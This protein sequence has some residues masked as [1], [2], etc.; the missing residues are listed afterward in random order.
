MLQLLSDT[1]P[2]F[3]GVS[4]PYENLD[5]L[6]KQISQKTQG[7]S[8]YVN[9]PERK[10]PDTDL[11]YADLDFTLQQCDRLKKQTSS[12]NSGSFRP[13]TLCKTTPTEN[14]DDKV[15]YTL[16]NIVATQAARL[17]SAEHQRDRES[18][19]HKLSN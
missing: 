9:L 17:A 8:N 12:K 19:A 15:E 11:N 13:P 5:G 1:T 4:S 14:D 2:L 18:G 16:I 10:K 3:T 6:H 7:N